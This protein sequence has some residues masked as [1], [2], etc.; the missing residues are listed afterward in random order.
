MSYE[1]SCDYGDA[2][3]FY[4]ACRPRARKQHVCEECGGP[5][6]P[7]EKYER[8]SGKW[9]SYVDTFLTCAR[10]VDLRTWVQNNVPCLCWSH[11]NGDERMAEAI[12]D[13]IERAPD[14]TV[15]LKFGF[16]RR[17]V[18]RDRH[19]KLARAN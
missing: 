4:R 19:N 17:K 6:R 12:E 14:E 1:C 3:A 9:D 8:V 10:C 11:G 16:L 2:P 7:G 18:L 5:I 15:G 13:A